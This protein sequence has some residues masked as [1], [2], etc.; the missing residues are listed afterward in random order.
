MM[1]ANNQVHYGPVVIF[2]CLHFT[3]PHDHHY[4]DISRGI[5]LLNCFSDTFCHVSKIKSILSIIFHVI[6][7]GQCVF[8]LPISLMMIERICVLYLVIIIK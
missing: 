4:A 3:L 5:E 2:I 7:M 8:N 6:Y 1:C